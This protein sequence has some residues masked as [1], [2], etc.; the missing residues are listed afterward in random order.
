MLLTVLKVSLVV[1]IGVAVI[2]FI[3]TYVRKSRITNFRTEADPNLGS[4][5]QMGVVPPT[6]LPEW[7]YWEDAEPTEPPKN[8]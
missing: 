6:P 5:S 4:L 7:A 3:A 8:T 2:V 1:F